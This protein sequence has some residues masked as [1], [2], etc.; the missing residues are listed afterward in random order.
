MSQLELFA[1]AH[2]RR[3]DPWT[4]HAAARSVRITRGQWLVLCLLGR[5]GPCT[6]ER[7]V[8]AAHTDRVRI[9][10]SGAR[11]RRAELVEAGLVEQVGESVTASGRRCLVWDL[12]TAGTDSVLRANDV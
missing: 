4:S 8:S 6:D 5:W 11:S 10:P 1:D 12:S 7:L 9:S 3:G 2:A